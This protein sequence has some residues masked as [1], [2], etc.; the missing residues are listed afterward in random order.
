MTTATSSLSL[1]IGYAI[2]RRREHM[3]KSVEWLAKKSGVDASVIAA[4]EIGSRQP[5]VDHL[6]HIG[7]ALGTSAEA[8]VR[9]ARKAPASAVPVAERLEKIARVVLGELPDALGDKLD[10]VERA[11]VT[12]AMEVSRGNQSAAARLLGLDRKALV[13]RWHNVQRAGR[14]QASN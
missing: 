6:D 13:R 2:R 14:R 8:L 3:G 5:T 4:I 9:D 11:I 10:A 7:V 12:H 1:A